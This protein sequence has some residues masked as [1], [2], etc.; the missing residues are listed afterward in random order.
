MARTNAERQKAY[1]DR[2]KQQQ[3]AQEL[4]MQAPIP[5]YNP[6]DLQSEPVSMFDVQ[7]RRLER[8]A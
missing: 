4:D 2:K 3:K 5:P 7:K 8:D 6:L 1:R